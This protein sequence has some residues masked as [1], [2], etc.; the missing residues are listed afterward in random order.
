MKPDLK[1]RL[2]TCLIVKHLPFGTL[3]NLNNVNSNL[4]STYIFA[5]FFVDGENLGISKLRAKAETFVV[6]VT[7]IRI[8]I[9]KQMRTSVTNYTL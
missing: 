4:Q 1:L 9:A 8:N 3:Y 7:I 2:Q 5:Q 6:K